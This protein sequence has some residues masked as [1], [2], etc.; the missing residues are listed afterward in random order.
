MSNQ[1]LLLY[2]FWVILVAITG[3]LISVNLLLNIVSSID[4]KL[5]YVININ[6]LTPLKI[7]QYYPDKKFILGQALFFDPV[8][9]GNRNISC[10]SCHL[11][12]K[13]LSDGR[14][15]SLGPSEGNFSRKLSN[16]M[17][18]QGVR[19]R[20]SPDLWNRD[21][22][23]V[24]NL[25]LDGRIEVLDSEK[26]IF[27]N[28]I[29]D[30]LLKQFQNALEVQAIFPIASESEMSGLF[31][32]KSEKNLPGEHADKVNDLVNKSKYKTGTEK[33]LSI[34]AQ[35]L[36]RLIS[37]KAMPETWQITYRNMF[38]EAYPEV[39]LNKLTIY[40]VGSAIGHFEELAFAAN[41][42]RWDQYLEGKTE[43]IN[44]QEKLGALI[45]FGKGYCS[46]CHMDTLLSD[47][48]FHN[49]GIISDPL[50]T[51]KGQFEDLGRYFV[52]KN[53]KDMYKFRTPPLRNVTKSAPYFH[54]GSSA[55]LYEALIRHT[56]PLKYENSFL[57]LYT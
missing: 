10:A 6:G 4:E 7:R 52:T 21:A 38:I 54:D 25:F 5:Q 53:K 22:I 39:N 3:Y 2:F 23:S 57:V 29:G 31:G 32:D 18:E 8:L 27:Q 1:K 44:N 42:S 55:T 15:F 56:N 9:S 24:K 37:R 51:P 47:F 49:I 26:K 41:N 11:V 36:E 46:S 33:I 43:A 34:H 14:Q 35:L 19:K 17:I 40:H 30:A 13:G 28:P 16:N 48:K 45:F 50:F 12:S 20:N